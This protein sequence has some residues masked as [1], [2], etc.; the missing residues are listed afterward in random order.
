[1]GNQT[2][3]IRLF[4][5]AQQKKREGRGWKPV[6]VTAGISLVLLLLVISFFAVQLNR[7]KIAAERAVKDAKKY[8]E[9]ISNLQQENEWFRAEAEHQKEVRFLERDIQIKNVELS[10]S[11]ISGYVQNSGSVEVGDIKLTALVKSADGTLNEKTITVKS[12]NGRPLMRWQRRP[13][14]IAL[15]IDPGPDAEA[16]VYINDVQAVAQ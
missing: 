6:A 2:R 5:E 7:Q 14:R 8:S 9:E 11:G 16:T 4:Q 10:G 12:S 15:D 1:V 13:F 3:I